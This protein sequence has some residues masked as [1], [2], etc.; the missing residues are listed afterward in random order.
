MPF[1]EFLEISNF[2]LALPPNGYAKEIARSAESKSARFHTNVLI[3]AENS[4]NF[5]KNF[6]ISVTLAELWR[7]VRVLPKQL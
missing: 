4:T 7:Q 1:S 6:A 5:A 3:F 2:A